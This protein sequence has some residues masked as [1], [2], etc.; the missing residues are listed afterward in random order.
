MLTSSSWIESIKRLL[1][2]AL[3]IAPL[4][5]AEIKNQLKIAEADRKLFPSVVEL[6]FRKNSS[7]TTNRSIGE[8][9]LLA[10]IFQ[11]QDS[12]YFMNYIGKRTNSGGA[13]LNIGL[14]RRQLENNV[15]S[16][17]YGFIDIRK[18]PLNNQ[19]W[20][21][22]LGQEHLSKVIDWRYNLYI[23]F[24][25]S[26][27]VP[28]HKRRPKV[29]VKGD[30]LSI[31]SLHKEY[32]M[33]GIDFEIG[34]KK[35]YPW[36][37]F[38]MW[39]GGYSFQD[40]HV[41]SING[42]SVRIETE[43]TNLKYLP[44]NITLKWGL[45]FQRDNVRGENLTAQIALS[46]PLSGTSRLN[47]MQRRMIEPVIRDVDIVSNTDSITEPAINLETGKSLNKIKRVKTG[48]DLYRATKLG[49]PNTLV[50]VEGDISTSLEAQAQKDQVF[51]S[52][53]RKVLLTTPSGA[54][55]AYQPS[56][57]PVRTIRAVTDGQMVFSS[58][59]GVVN[60][61]VL[62]L[63]KNDDGQEIA[64]NSMVFYQRTVIARK[65]TAF[66][67]L[68][69][70]GDGYNYELECED[71][72]A[73]CTNIDID[74][75]TGQITL[76]GESSGDLHIVRVIVTKDRVKY[77]FV[78]VIIQTPDA[79]NVANEARDRLLPNQAVLNNGITLRYGNNFRCSGDADVYG[80]RCDTDRETKIAYVERM[81]NSLLSKKPG[82][83]A[84]IIAALKRNNPTLTLFNTADDKNN[85]NAY[86]ALNPDT[87][88]L[89]ADETFAGSGNNDKGLSA[90]GRAR[91]AALEEIVHMIHNYGITD[92]F[93][94]WQ[95]RLDRATADA[96]EKGYL[97]LWDKDD[98][99][100]RDLDDEYFADS[101]EAYFNVRGGLGVTGSDSLCS[102]GGIEGGSRIC[103]DGNTARDDLKLNHR[104]MYNLVEEIFGE[105]NNL[106]D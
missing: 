103:A 51:I 2:L 70:I 99:P 55:V 94:E 87:Q 62:V 48:A 102:S 3:L 85:A 60:K 1:L 8:V 78:D 36:G 71:D 21:L 56:T 38:A 40:K 5:Q 29:I 43:L 45:Q 54:V 16:G 88:D 18:T 20:Q 10:P 64:D 61:G 4:A 77:P 90:N 100:R 27:D 57:G 25:G 76:G 79:I 47:Y 97:D 92:A 50:V 73:D 89:Q 19:F 46:I 30:T 14:G 24:S 59:K 44:K 58:N 17:L 12:F 84:K 33:H 42:P 95:E 26:K 75:N 93:P 23:P 67:P 98:L 91:N 104:D 101:V 68:G 39:L 32:A 22:T 6:S 83:D 11:N 41:S 31:Q 7:R 35:P 66:N 28:K 96:L 37:S 13:E 63:N 106:F 82:V 80:V 9:N 69:N 49:D 52:G 74:P 15:I 72:Y 86:L 105:S 34:H 65:G 81:I 53:N